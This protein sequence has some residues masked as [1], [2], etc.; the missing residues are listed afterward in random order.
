MASSDGDD[1]TD[2]SWEKI[3]HD[4]PSPVQQDRIDDPL[5][6]P[7]SQRQ[8]EAGEEDERHGWDTSL[9][10]LLP[11]RLGIRSISSS[12]YGSTLARLL[13]FPQ[14]VG[15]LGGTPRHALWF[16]G[17]DAVEP[18]PRGSSSSS[19]DDKND[20]TD[21]SAGGIEG[22]WYGLDPHTVQ[23]APRGT[24]V[25]SNTK[26]ANE[27]DVANGPPTYLWQVQ[28]TDTYLRS[29]HFSPM[30]THP[31]HGRSIPLSGLDPSCALGFYLR[32]HADFSDFKNSIRSLRDEHCRPNKLPEVVTVLKRTPDYEADVSSA[33]RGMMSV[34][35]GRCR[36]HGGGVGEVDTDLDGFSMQSEDEDDGIAQEEEDD[37]DDDDFVLI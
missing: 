30:T 21:D 23:L 19:K 27:A 31:N 2:R 12:D 20:T 22:G 13:S 9:L 35:S 14:S 36:Q 7:P 15:M 3:S 8:G 17:A 25:L 18:P 10:L 32:D 11:L 33:V 24:R 26:T 6:L 37:D 1:A 16:Y 5:R 28:L 4:P 34:A 29:L